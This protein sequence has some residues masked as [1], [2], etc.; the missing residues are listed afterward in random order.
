MHVMT[1]T[2]KVRIFVQVLINTVGVSYACFQHDI[3]LSLIW[4]VQIQCSCVMFYILLYI[5]GP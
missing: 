1:E 2:D 4:K 5:C 3:R